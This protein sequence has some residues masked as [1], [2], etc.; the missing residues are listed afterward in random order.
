ML[1]SKSLKPTKN[2]R[3]QSRNYYKSKKYT[4][5]FFQESKKRKRHFA[6]GLNKANAATIS[7]I[8]VFCLLIWFLIYSKYFAISATEIKGEGR[9][10]PAMIEKLVWEQINSSYFVLFPQKNIFIFNKND[11][12]SLLEE[13]FAFNN[14]EIKKKIPN[15]LIIRFS[16]KEYAIIWQEGES[17]YYGDS[18]GYVI[19]QLENTLEVNK[20]DY[21][22]IQNQKT[23]KLSE[24]SADIE[25][26]YISYV[27]ELFKRF[28]ASTEIPP[29]DF[30]IIDDDVNTVKIK[31]VD[32]PK[33]FF[34]IN[35]DMDKQL[36]K[37]M[38]IK[39]EK[40]KEDFFKKEYID[41]RIG[42]SIYIR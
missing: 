31:L 28:K 12:K 22:L 2:F 39:N 15:K 42:D 4:N 5:P 14:L 7:G 32:G 40:L 18:Q 38:I 11:L 24:N 34:N 3:S 6:L 35:E 8:L 37:V 17:Y 33:L 25:E 41:V 16:E 13:R 10:D 21:P 23:K 20:K 1:D 30:F 29:L 36:N 26:R 9:I 27:L 19:T